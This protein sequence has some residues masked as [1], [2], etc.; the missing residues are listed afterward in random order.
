MSDHLQKLF[1]V[2]DRIV[3]YRYIRGSY[4]ARFRREGYNIEVAAKSFELMKQKFLLRLLEEE[5]KKRNASFPLFG[6]FVNDWL[7]IK[8]QTV[9]ES[10]YKSY[11]NL[12]SCTVLPKFSDVHINEITRKDIQDFLFELTDQGKKRTAQKLKMI[13]GAIFDVAAEDYN[14]K[15]PMIKI[16]LAHYEVKKGHAFTKEEER[17]IVEFCKEN[18]H[19]AGNSALLTLLYTGM[20]VGE[21]ATITFDDTYVRCESEKTRKGYATVIRNIPISPMFRRVMSMVDL[22]VAKETNKFTIRDA[23]KRIFPDR[24]VHELRYTYIT[25]AK[26]CGV[27][28]EVVMKWVGHEYDGDVKT[29]RVDRGYTTYSEEFL[30]KE[31]NKIEYNL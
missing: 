19:Y 2:N 5:K 22:Q 13:L 29:S 28:G 6:D 16:V 18:P 3:S 21:L 4:Q 11:C 27:A 12:L 9:K 23:L 15:S 14:I 17:Q 1:T 7:K 24:H 26:E 30:L 10:T 8:K 25:R 31:N 20:R